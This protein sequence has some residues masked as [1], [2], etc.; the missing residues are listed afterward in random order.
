MK[1]VNF[2]PEMQQTGVDEARWRAAR[3]SLARHENL[4]RG[5]RDITGYGLGVKY[6]K[7]YIMVFVRPGKRREVEKVIPNTLDEFE[8][9]YREASPRALVR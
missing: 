9:Y 5:N 2:D 3:A 8:V 1:R 6:G 7:P 4:F